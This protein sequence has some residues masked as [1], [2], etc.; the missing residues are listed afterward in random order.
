MQSPEKVGDDEVAQFQQLLGHNGH[1][2]EQ[3]EEQLGENMLRGP[4][5]DGDGGGVLARTAPRRPDHRLRHKLYRVPHG[6]H[7]EDVQWYW[8][9]SQ[10]WIGLIGPDTTPDVENI[11]PI[12][13]D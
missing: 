5:R 3:A 2:D 1:N 10:L 6:D 8:P 9:C 7:R 13:G 11:V 4:Q 12:V